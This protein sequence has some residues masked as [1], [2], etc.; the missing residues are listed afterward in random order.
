MR[1]MAPSAFVSNART[2]DAL[3]SGAKAIPAR[4]MIV[5]GALASRARATS[6]SDRTSSIVHFTA[7]R[8]SAFSNGA[9]A[10]QSTTPANTA[11]PCRSSARVSHWPTNP[12][13][14]VMRTRRAIPRLQAELAMPGHVGIHHH[15]DQLGERHLRLPTEFLLCLGGITDEHVHLGRA[16]E[17][18]I[19][20]DVLLPIET[21]VSEGDLTQFTHGVHL[22]G[23]DDIVVRRLLLQH[24]PH[25]FDVVACIAP[26]AAR[27][28]VPE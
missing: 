14:P 24:H 26:V 4:W 18:L 7:E 8:S 16:K 28:E 27:I 12:A 20:N 6:S 15:P 2:G 1:R 23:G 21:H 5:S 11:S 13:P 3:A 17:L 9:R 25:R 22:A 19:L 10:G